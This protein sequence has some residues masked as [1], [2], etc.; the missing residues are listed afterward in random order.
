MEEQKEQAIC[1]RDSSYLAPMLSL[2]RWHKKTIE[3]LK[4]RERFFSRE[5]SR[6]A[7]S[8][9]RNLLRKSLDEVQSELRK[10]YLLWKRSKFRER[11]INRREKGFVVEQDK[12]LMSALHKQ[13]DILTEKRKGRVC[14]DNIHLLQY[15]YTLW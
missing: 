5:L 7:D 11:L 12:L 13:S 14:N 15:L 4:L 10:Q 6:E 3:R 8:R 9:K 1:H 2:G